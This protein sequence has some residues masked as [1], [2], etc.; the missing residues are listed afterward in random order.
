MTA[1]ALLTS[2]GLGIRR[3]SL[4]AMERGSPR[5]PRKY[6]SRGRQPVLM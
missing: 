3:L 2:T 6:V 1:A 4:T 5:F